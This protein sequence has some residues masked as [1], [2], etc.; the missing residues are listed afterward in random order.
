[1]ALPDFATLVRDLRRLVPRDGP[2]DPSSSGPGPPRATP[3]LGTAFVRAASRARGPA[4]SPRSSQPP[5]R[6]TR[7]VL[8]STV[9]GTRVRSLHRAARGVPRRVPPSRAT[10]QARKSRVVGLRRVNRGGE[11]AGA[12]GRRS[13]LCVRLCSAALLCAFALHLCVCLRGCCCLSRCTR[14]LVFHQSD[15]CL[16]PRDRAVPAC[17]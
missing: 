5:P 8:R 6:T 13:A 15:L 4:P 2:S 9:C 3:N 1:M 7:R 17:K 12:G 14:P 16:Y 11:R 10:R